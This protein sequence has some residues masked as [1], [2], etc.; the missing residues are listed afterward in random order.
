[1]LAVDRAKVVDY[2]ILCSIILACVLITAAIWIL[3]LRPRL[4]GGQDEETSSSYAF[5]IDTL[6]KMR[7]SGQISEDE[8]RKLRVFALGI[9]P[10][11]AEKGSAPA[12]S[13]SRHPPEAADDQ[14]D[15]QAGDD[16]QQEN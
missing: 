1:M 15:R 12:D 13:T 5:D 2:V 11:R 14:A 9:G 6:E 7:Q 8:F 3:F 10:D 4:L 16:A